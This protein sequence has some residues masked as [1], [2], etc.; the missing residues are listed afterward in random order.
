MLKALKRAFFD[1]STN[2]TKWEKIMINGANQDYSW[3]ESAKKYITLY[4]KATALKQ[5]Y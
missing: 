3:K 2:K 4:K 5:S 1:Y